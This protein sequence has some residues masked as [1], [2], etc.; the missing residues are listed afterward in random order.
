MPFDGI[1]TRA[2][3]TE[4]RHSIL[5]GKIDKVY[6]PVREELVFNVRKLGDTRKLFASVESS[7]PRIHF[8][9]KSP[10]NPANPFPFCML[11]RKHLSGGK[12]LSVEQVGSDRV[13]E[14][15]VQ[16][17]N[18]MGVTTLKTLI[19]EI[20]GKHS[21]IV[22]VNGSNDI[23]IDSI[24]RIS[25][26]TS[27]ARQ[28]LPGKKYEYPPAQDKI[29]F[30]EIDS[31]TLKSLPDNPKLILSSISGISPIFAT[32]ISESEDRV[33]F[34][35]ETISLSNSGKFIPR[36]YF[37]DA[38]PVDYH[39]TDLPQ[40]EDV[41]KKHTFTTLSECVDTFFEGK[42]TSGRIIER[43]KQ[44]AKSVSTLL[45]KAYLKKKRLS[46][47][48]L[49]AGDSEHLRIKGELLTASLHSIKNGTKTVVVD[50]YYDGTKVPIDLDERYSPAK[51]AQL[52]FKKYAK[53]KTAI[54]EKTLQLSE[55]ENDIKYLESV[56]SHIENVSSNEEIELIRLELIDSGYIKKKRTREKQVKFKLSPYKYVSPSGF[57]I[58]VGRN[59]R[60]ND[61]LTMKLASKQDL[62]FHTK[63]IPG[64]HVI[65]KT[66]GSAYEIENIADDIYC[67]ASI[68]A[69]HSKARSSSNVPVD[70][71]PV[72]HVK[73]PAGAKFGMV[74]FTNNSTVYVD[75]KIP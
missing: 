42:S 5:G 70:Y 43:S 47:D 1:V 66:A 4:I 56:L 9:D 2:M 54:R 36:I 14:I 18:E 63:D 35:N 52:Y 37:N 24:K 69:W 3:A 53:S 6:Q 21:N 34:L 11:L 73:K 61:M 8:I 71:V 22:L 30:D 28:L 16:T 23:V 26:D 13:I 50:N 72:R 39:I 25:I 44:L 38:S 48:L 67:A 59:N 64:A 60:E 55:N 7:S 20:M 19:F 46:E 68:A 33:R 29:P 49:V 17:L 15:K 40:Y 57:D 51:N 75:P 65:M 62:W 74:I 10:S 45:D 41:F 32:S 31:E 27:R 12:I 58:L